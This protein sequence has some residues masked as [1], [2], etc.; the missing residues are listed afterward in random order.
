MR[1]DWRSFVVYA[2]DVQILFAFA[3]GIQ[4]KFFLFSG[5]LVRG[6]KRRF[7][8]P[9]FHLNKA[10]LVN[11][12]FVTLKTYVFTL[13]SKQNKRCYYFSY[14]YRTIRICFNENR[15]WLSFMLFSFS[16]SYWMKMF[17]AKCLT[18][19]C[20]RNGSNVASL[21]TIK[22]KNREYS[23]APVQMIPGFNGWF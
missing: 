14:E 4:N 9:L 16:C 21:V 8:Y 13:F 2:N 11:N 6:H 15:V 3:G 23:L 20:I 12:I 1:L 7:F 17:A 19:Y 10:R 18:V 22:I 5:D